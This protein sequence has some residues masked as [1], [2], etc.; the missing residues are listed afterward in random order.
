VDMVIVAAI[1][2]VAIGAFANF[3]M[4]EPISHSVLAKA[5]QH[6]RFAGLAD[7]PP[8]DASHSMHRPCRERARRACPRAIA[9]REGDRIRRATASHARTILSR[10]HSGRSSRIQSREG[11]PTGRAPRLLLPCQL[12]A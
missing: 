2:V 5:E 1:V 3:I 7:E 9:G 10:S 12:L 11:I 6:G 8:R 4:A